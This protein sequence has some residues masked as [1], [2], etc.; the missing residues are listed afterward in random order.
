MAVVILA[1]TV[2]LFFPALGLATGAAAALF[3]AMLGLA[4]L[5]VLRPRSTRS[6]TAAAPAVVRRPALAVAVAAVLFAGHRAAVDH[7]DADHP[8][9]A[10]LMYAL[11]TDTG[12]AQWVSAETPAG[13]MGQPV[14]HRIGDRGGHLRA[15]ARTGD[16]RARPGGGPPGTAGD[17]RR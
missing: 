4:L 9:P 7:F 12:Q 15:G 2:L 13:G 10:Q 14:R 16:G 3:S 17:R 11:D 5:P 8:A 6:R 1:P